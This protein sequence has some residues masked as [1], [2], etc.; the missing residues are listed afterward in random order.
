MRLA[1][2]AVSAQFGTSILAAGDGS[3]T[4]IRDVASAQIAAILRWRMDVRMA[5]SL[6]IVQKSPDGAETPRHVEHCFPH[7]QGRI[8]FRTLCKIFCSMPTY[9]ACD[10]HHS[11]GDSHVLV[12]PGFVDR[13]LAKLS[14][15]KLSRKPLE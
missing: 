11:G 7:T 5:P 8:D 9:E 4:S 14:T 12:T 6:A 2:D 3:F 13:K 10:T 15:I 1:E